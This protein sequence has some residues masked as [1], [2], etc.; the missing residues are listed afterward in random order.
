MV[1]ESDDDPPE[2]QDLE[3]AAEWR[4]RKVDADPTDRQSA[5]AAQRLKALA[6]E[7]R[8]LQDDPLFLEYR[9]I[10]NWLDEFGGMEDF[11]QL[12]NAYRRDIGLTDDP[13]GA[14]AYLRALLEMARQTFGTS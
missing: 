5:R 9:A 10:A 11:A 12:A 14:R 2:V 7:L 8:I 6:A 3:A 13:D 4:L 1:P